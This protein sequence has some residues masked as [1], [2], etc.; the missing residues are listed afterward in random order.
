MRRIRSRRGVSSARSR[1]AMRPSANSGFAW[2]MI[3]SYMCAMITQ[4]RLTELLTYD[5]LTGRFTNRIRRGQRCREGQPFGSQHPDGYRYGMLDGVT[6]GEHVLAWVYVYGTIP[7]GVRPDHRDRVRDNNR[8]AN[9]RLAT[10]SQ[11]SMNSPGKGAKSGFKG[12][13]YRNNRSGT[14]LWL[15]RIRVDGR[16]IHIGHFDTA[17]EAAAAYDAEAKSRFGEFAWLNFP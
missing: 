10:R 8:I 15:A 5:P 2:A 17:V 3:T 12:V 6:Y 7:E 11:N 14:K 16:L 13:T 9:L 4:A 1:A